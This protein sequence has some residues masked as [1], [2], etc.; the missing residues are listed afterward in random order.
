MQSMWN[1]ARN[2][3]VGP[4]SPPPSPP[5]P[6]PSP[7]HPL[8]CRLPIHFTPGHPTATDLQFWARKSWTTSYKLWMSGMWGPYRTEYNDD[9]CISYMGDKLSKNNPMCSA[10]CNQYQRPTHRQRLGPTVS[11]GF[12]S[13]SQPTRRYISPECFG[14]LKGEYRLVWDGTVI[15]QRTK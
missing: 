12:N 2:S 4:P 5:H 7:P 14:H 11:G 13:I 3:G 10:T 8:P 1:I 15:P 6:P 9:P